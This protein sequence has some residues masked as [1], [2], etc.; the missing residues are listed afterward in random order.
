MAKESEVISVF[1]INLRHSVE[2]KA[3][4]QQLCEEIGLSPVFINAIDG[5]FIKP[6]EITGLYSNKGSVNA[7]GRELSMGEMGCAL[8]HKKI[9]KKMVDDNIRQALIFEDDVEFDAE[10]LGVLTL[11]DNLPFDWELILLGH[12]GAKSRKE[13]TNESFWGRVQLSSNFSLRRACDLAYGAY[14]Y[15]LN[16]QGALRLLEHLQ[17]IDKPLDHYTGDSHN[18]NLYTLYPPVVHISKF[19]SDNHHAMQD[20]NIMSEQLR[21]QRN[22]QNMS[23]YKKLSM[24]W[25]I[26]ALLNSLYYQLKGWFNKI[27]PIR[28]YTCL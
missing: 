28:K 15:L 25:G 17:C 4:M 10:L 12:H 18:L 1:I 23:W 19:L 24:S 22:E 5:A 2:R 3:H 16:Y 8:S 11:K 27:K 9:Y 20:R 14:G 7:I 6:S 13:R 26:Y 21:Y